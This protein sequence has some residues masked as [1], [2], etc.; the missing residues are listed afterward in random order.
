MALTLKQN[1]LAKLQMPGQQ[2]SQ[3]AATQGV[4]NQT[5]SLQN[6]IAQMGQTPVTQPVAQQAG[7]AQ[8]TGAGQIANAQVAADAQNQLQTAGN[9]MAQ[10]AEEASQR[11][12]R[13]SLQAQEEHRSAT[14]RLGALNSQLKTKLFDSQ[15][16]FNRDELGRTVFNEQQLLDYKLAQGMADEDLLNYEQTA[17][18]MTDRKLQM[19]KT[20]QAKIMSELNQEFSSGQQELDQAHKKALVEQKRAIEEKI[21]KEQA[22]AKNRGAMFSAAGTVIGAVAGG[23]VAG[24]AGA[25]VGASAGGAIG[26]LAASQ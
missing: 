13:K 10:G 4:S 17:R 7:A 9:V 8:A 24:P 14:D 26:G 3:A 12:Q 6:S 19:L 21:R 15:M 25:T 18:Q 5:T 16:N 11:M 2:A 23:M 22:K 20:A 1:Q